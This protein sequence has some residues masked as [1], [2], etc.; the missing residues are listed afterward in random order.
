[1]FDTTNIDIWS[2]AR[3]THLLW[4]RK[5]A[6]LPKAKQKAV[7]HWAHG[8]FLETYCA[9]CCGPM[10]PWATLLGL[11]GPMVVLRHLRASSSVLA[12]TSSS[13]PASSRRV[14]K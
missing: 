10:E 4:A 3:P 9:M 13:C 14:N 11:M 5:C 12:E 8:S 1:M 2:E 7:G 6:C